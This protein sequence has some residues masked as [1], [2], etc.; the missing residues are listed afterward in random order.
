MCTHLWRYATEVE[1]SVARKTTGPCR[2]ERNPSMARS[3]A[4]N[5]QHIDM[6]E[7]LVFCPFPRQCQ[8]GE[9]STQSRR[10]RIHVQGCSGRWP[11][12]RNSLQNISFLSPPPCEVPL[13]RCRSPGRQEEHL[14]RTD[15]QTA[16]RH[17]N[18]R[19]IQVTEKAHKST[20]LNT[21][22]RDQKRHQQTG[23]LEL[24]QWGNDKAQV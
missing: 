13:G 11:V 22:H 18:S 9:V 19:R 6:L 3:T 20:Y 1:L 15:V 10:R 8:N 7:E 4:F 23:S 2:E 14:K 12:E 17:N 21:L 16:E 5:L 24:G